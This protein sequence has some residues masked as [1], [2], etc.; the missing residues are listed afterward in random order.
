MSSV[1]RIRSSFGRKD[2]TKLPLFGPLGL[3]LA[4]HFAFPWAA[5]VMKYW[6]N[7]LLG[8]PFYLRIILGKGRNDSYGSRS[9]VQFL[10]QI[11]KIA[12]NR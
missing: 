2:S 1:R 7:L 5:E 3:K 12:A 9:Q 8:C 10:H 4:C 6:L 11:S